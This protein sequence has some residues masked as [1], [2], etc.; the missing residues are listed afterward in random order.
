M[1]MTFKDIVKE[2]V[3]P[4]VIITI[5]FV[6]MLAIGYG[7]WTGETTGN[8]SLTAPLYGTELVVDEQVAGVSKNAG[9][10]LSYSFPEGKHTVIVARGGFLPW[11][12]DITVK[13]K[14]TTELHPFLVRQDIKPTEIAQNVYDGGTITINTEYSDAL[15]LFD[16]ASTKP[17]LS[18][19]IA[20]TKIKD[21]RSADY[22][23]GRTDV[24]LIAAQNGVFAVETGSTTPRNF[25]P[26]YQGKEPTFVLSGGSIIVKEGT[27]L[28]R[29]VG[30][31]R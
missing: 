2:Q 5:I 27:T 16:T 1:Q 25:E 31:D 23:P 6:V 15:S 13:A 17:E 3:P 11:T 21:V 9:E 7:I 30:F 14:E 12:K 4:Q 8:I 26:V 20:E 19:L 22:Y 10:K 24:L 28:Y 18:S 29:I